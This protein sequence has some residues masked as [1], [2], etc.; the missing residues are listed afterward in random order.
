MAFLLK[1]T[2]RENAS[3]NGT[4]DVVC[5]AKRKMGRQRYALGRNFG[6]K[7]AS[8]YECREQS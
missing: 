5:A 4:M 7:G 8:R 3:T 2:V 6:Q 1:Y